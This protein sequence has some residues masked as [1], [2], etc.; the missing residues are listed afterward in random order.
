LQ[1]LKEWNALFSLHRST[2]GSASRSSRSK[3]RPANRSA[4]H[5]RSRNVNRAPRPLSIISRASAPVV[6]DLLAEL[7]VVHPSQIDPWLAST[8]DL[9]EE[10]ARTDVG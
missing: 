4:S 5:A 6:G 10:G 3:T 1:P 9:V 7:G 8:E 2:S